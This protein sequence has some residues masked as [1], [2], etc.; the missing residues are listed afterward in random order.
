MPSIPQRPVRFPQGLTTYPPR[1][2][3]QTYPVAPLPSQISIGEDFIPYRT[4][5]HVITTAVGG[6]AATFN[7]I[8][9]MVRLATSGSATDTIYVQRNAYSMQVLPGN[10]M[11]MD[12]RLAYPRTVN[13]ANDTSIFWGLFDAATPQ[14]ANNGIY[15]NKPAGGTAVHFVIKKAGVTT[16]FQNIGDL[17]LPSGL[18]N[19]TNA[20]NGTLNAVVAG[21][22]LTGISV[23]TP[24]AGYQISPLV[25]TTSASGSAGLNIASVTLG[26]SAIS[27][28]NPPVPVQTTGLQYGSLSA[29]YVTAP[30]SGLT[31]SAGS[32]AY[33]EVIPVLN[34]AVWFDAKGNLYVGVNGRQVM[35]VGGTATMTNAVGVAAGAT[36]N[37]ATS[38]SAGFYSTTQLSTA[39]APFQP[40]IGSAYNLLPQVSLAYLFGFSNTTANV[41]TLFVDEYNVAVEF[42]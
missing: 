14:L 34:F 25:L 16:T 13:N 9:G 18:Y 42:N 27:Q 28:S 6:T 7:A 37:V 22:L 12:T 1:H 24:G 17:A 31:N 21:N 10:Q 23:A 30:G 32:A 20:V 29:P 5:D 26:S 3:L 33:L 41:R 35:A 38:A 8:A 36:V 15:F 2:V 19:D 11:W 40:P 39:V 4:A